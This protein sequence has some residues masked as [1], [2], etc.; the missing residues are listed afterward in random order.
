MK[1]NTF[2]VLKP[3]EERIL[4]LLQKEDHLTVSSIS[5]K[6]K[7]SRTS[8]YNSLESLRKKD[9]V[10]KADFIYSLKNKELVKYPIDIDTPH[11]KI[12]DLLEEIA[13][14]KRGEIIYSIET[15]A[16]I[17]ELFKDRNSFEKWQRKI[18]NNEIVLKGVGSVAALDFFKK[19][20][21]D[22][23]RKIL[24]RRSGSARFLKEP[25][26]GYCVLVVFKNSI[27]FMSRVKKYF[28]RIDDVYIS[29]FMKSIVD[30]IYMNQE[31]R[32]LA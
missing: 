29:E 7:L 30:Q 4:L 16:E 19:M 21:N 31:H 9:I 26:S 14:Q 15:D 27:V 23:D 6:L 32:R 17:K 5:K 25:L 2:L 1:S 13:E 10:S 8:I 3:T 20:T 22:N 12:E 18:T 24:G 11:K 28:Y